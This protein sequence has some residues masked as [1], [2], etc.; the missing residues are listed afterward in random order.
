MTDA[1]VSE[2]M[3]S[4]VLTIASDTPIA[5]AADAMRQ[6]EIKSIVVIDDACAPQGILTST[7]VLDVAAEKADPTATTVSEYMTA[8]VE[9]VTA[10]EPVTSAAGRMLESGINHVPVLESPEGTVS[11]ILTTT[12]LVSVL[13]ERYRHGAT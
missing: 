12:D 6:S 4:P 5:A 10:D 8:D 11:G 1:P 3:T 7:D 2:H 13:S 9:T